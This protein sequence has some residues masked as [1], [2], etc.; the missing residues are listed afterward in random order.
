MSLKFPRQPSS[1]QVKIK[2]ILEDYMNDLK[3]NLS[4][5]YQR[6]GRWNNKL[7]N[8]LI[9]TIMCNMPSI[10]E[11]ITYK[12]QN[13]NIDNYEF[14][15]IDGHH[16]FEVIDHF[17][18]SKPIILQNKNPILVH[19]NENENTHVFYKE[20]SETIKYKE[21]NETLTL[22]VRYMSNEE[23]KVFEDY[24]LNIT[25]INEKM[26]Y[27]ERMK[28]FNR[29]QNGIRVTNSDLYKNFYEFETIKY[30]NEDVIEL[31]KEYYDANTTIKRIMYY[32]CTKNAEKYSIEWC[33]RCYSIVKSIESKSSVDESMYSR[34]SDR[35]TTTDTEYKRYITHPRKCPSIIDFD[36][37][38]FD[39]FVKSTEMFYGILNEIQANDPKL[40]LSPCQLYA[41]FTFI[42]INKI[43]KNFINNVRIWINQNKKDVRNKL[44]FK[45]NTKDEMEKY[46][47]YCINNYELLNLEDNELPTNEKRKKFSTKKRE[48]IFQKSQGKCI[49]CGDDINI[50]RF[51]CCHI[52]A[53]SKG[54]KNNLNNLVAGCKKCNSEMG[55]Q[56]LRDYMYNI[57]QRKLEDY[58]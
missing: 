57:H 4:P 25:E 21:L 15:C 37:N 42:A 8:E 22:K 35:F 44:W 46:Y 36:E 18:N 28:F 24:L 52:I 50:N 16:R 19:W 56:C 30:M 32:Y 11:L 47:L 14:E 10:G 40:K 54:G 48:K 5:K 39:K 45:K 2:H 53:L 13:D 43:S 7:A 31:N 3:L 51:D 26:S 41:L 9:D 12:Y 17:Y 49:P 38:I 23:K 6:P 20:S 55:T 58:I 29:V 34:Y 27:E 33:L 1:R